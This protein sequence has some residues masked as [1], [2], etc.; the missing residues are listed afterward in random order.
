MAAYRPRMAFVKANAVKRTMKVDTDAGRVTA[1]AGDYVVVFPNDARTVLK[2]DFFESM[3]ENAEETV[4]CDV[5][6]DFDGVLHSYVSGWQGA[7]VIPDPPVEG[8]VLKLR[9]YLAATLKLAVHSARSAQA[10]GIQAM[11]SWIDHHDAATRR[12]EDEPLVDQLLFPFHKPAAKV[13]LDDRGL[14]FTGK[15]PSVDELMRSFRVWNEADKLGA[16]R[17]IL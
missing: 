13:Y 2:K 17:L 11:H 5:C 1:E 10:D 9:S 7:S 4:F 6:L 12:P 15:F 8:M 14:R 16:K 3:Y